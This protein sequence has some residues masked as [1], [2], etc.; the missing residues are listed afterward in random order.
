LAILPGD[1]RGC[2]ADD[3]NVSAPRP[4]AH[5]EHEFASKVAAAQAAL[6][7]GDRSKAIEALDAI[8]AQYGGA[9]ESATY[10]LQRELD[11]RH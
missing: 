4:L 9:A 11:G 5:I 2:F 8:D 1:S 3:R 7:A 6:D 10:P